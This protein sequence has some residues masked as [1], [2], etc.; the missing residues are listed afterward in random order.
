MATVN[1]HCLKTQLG[2]IKS[3]TAYIHTSPYFFFFFFL[4][5]LLY[6]KGWKPLTGWYLCQTDMASVT[7]GGAWL[8]QGHGQ[9][10]VVLLLVREWGGRGEQ[11]EL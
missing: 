8:A 10:L 11:L 1:G 4:M 6:A 3:W 2:K 5:F 7:P 9:D